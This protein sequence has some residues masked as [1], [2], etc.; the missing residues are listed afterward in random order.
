MIGYPVREA[1]SNSVM[2]RLIRMSEMRRILYMRID[3]CFG[4]PER[5]I[6]CLFK[7]LDLSRYQPHLAP[8][9]C[10][11]KLAQAT[12]AM[13]VP[14]LLIPMSS[15]LAVRSARKRLI[16]IIEENDINLIHTLGIRS[17]LVAGPVARE[18]GIPWVARV[19][20]LNYT[21]YRNRLV[22]WL[23]HRINNRLLRKADAVQVISTPLRDYFQSLPRPP[24]RIELIPN[25]IDFPAPV[26]EETRRQAR[27]FFG[28]GEDQ[29]VIGSLGRIEP[30][31][32]YDLLFDCLVELPSHSVVLLGGEGSQAGLLKK[33]A[34]SGGLANR[35]HLGG[36]IEDTRFFLAACDIYVQPSRSEGVPM[37]LLEA[38]AAG[39]PVVASRVG[40]IGDVIRNGEDGFLILPEDRMALRN[41]LMKLC[42]DPEMREDFGGRAKRRVEQIGSAEDMTRQV[43][44]LYDDLLLSSSR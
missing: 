31:K 23:F 3:G 30:I 25:G 37:A 24:R 9:V 40:G 34:E 6:L 10:E 17:N 33:K 11:D 32:G 5:Y 36:F 39:L 13:G 8:L 38:M 12:R 27:E 22:G 26:D 28:I 44:A 16:S 2:Y 43:E 21:D 15:R 18:L 7:H 4:G 14:V 35:F 41:Y 29:T 42:R 1:H 19:P 20:N